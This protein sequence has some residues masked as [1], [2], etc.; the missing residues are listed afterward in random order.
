MTGIKLRI[1]HETNP[2]KYFPAL[3]ELAKDKRIELVGTHRY[4]VVKECLRAWQRDRTSLSKCVNNAF[5]DLLF[6]FCIPFVKNETIVMGFA[7]W[8]WR[9]LIYRKLAAQNRILYH[10]SWHDWG[11]D[12]TPRQPKPRWFKR[13]LQQKWHD[14]IAHP[15]VKV[16]AV[17]SAV[18][19]S[20]K[21][22][23]GI[24]AC[25]IPH[26]VPDVFFQ[27]GANRTLREFSTL[28][29]LYVGEVSE[30]K[31][32]KVLINLMK[33]L[34]DSKVSLTIVGNGPL[35]SQIKAVAENINYLGP[36][37]DREKLAKVMAEH[38]V[39][40]LLSQK[41]KTWEELFGIVLVETIAAGCSVIAS[42]HIGPRGILASIGGRGLFNEKDLKGV[43]KLVNSMIQ[44]P[45]VVEELTKVQSIAEAYSTEFVREQWYRELDVA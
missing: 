38:D 29:L 22:E 13:Y 45:S 8:D 26:A 24:E 30:K 3:F 35:V 6:R 32:I 14:F 23:M 40:M 20:V 7:P 41:T 17:T 44:D 11:V 31:G 28:K 27:A 36:V 43:L 25:V 9:L 2:R 16:I 5:Y 1:I 10:T 19:D 4:S 18:S 42:N 15:N 33:Q 34:P 21:R 39:L 12:N 37:Y